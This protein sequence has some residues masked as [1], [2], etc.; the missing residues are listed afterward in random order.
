MD[1]WY[2]IRSKPQ[3]EQ[4][5]WEQ[6]ALRS[7]KA[8]LPEIRV[9]PVNPRARTSRPFFTGYLFLRI[10]IEKTGASIFNT[11]PG[12]AGLVMFGG[13][14]ASIPDAVWEEIHQKVIELNT[15]KEALEREIPK[16]TP[17]WIREGPLSGYQ[18]IFD[19][20]LPDTER[21]RVLIRLVR[22]QQVRVELPL[23]Q[24][25]F[26]EFSYR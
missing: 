12:S 19:M 24:V 1:R 23:G 14:A 10:D 20:R 15:R 26:S 5:L 3:K 25:A 21:I 18:A 16:G 8:D 17:V 6:L 2:A 4:F 13:E 11:I 9:K 22:D 7:I